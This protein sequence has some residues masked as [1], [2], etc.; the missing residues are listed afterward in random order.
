MSTTVLNDD[1]RR[2]GAPTKI[3]ASI[4]VLVFAGAILTVSSLALFTDSADVT[5]NSFATGNVDISA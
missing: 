1:R 5:G 4:A 2:N 3:L